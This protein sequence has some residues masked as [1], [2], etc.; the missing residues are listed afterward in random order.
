MTNSRTQWFL[1][2]PGYVVTA[3]AVLICTCIVTIFVNLSL[4]ARK[5]L[6]PMEVAVPLFQMRDMLRALALGALLIV[7]LKRSEL[8]R[9][10]LK[11]ARRRAAIVGIITFL[12]LVHDFVLRFVPQREAYDA[13]GI[14]LVNTVFHMCVFVTLL[15]SLRVHRARCNTLGLEGRVFQDRAVIIVC[16]V[17]ISVSVARGWLVPLLDNW[18]K[19]IA[20]SPAFALEDLNKVRR[21]GTIARLIQSLLELAL[22]VTIFYVYK[23][24]RRGIVRF[25][26]SKCPVCGY[27]LARGYPGCPECGWARPKGAESEGPL[28]RHTG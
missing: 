27:V 7:F 2:Q 12:I 26:A 14:P 9:P 10:A 19:G 22:L 17:F 24:F 6:L 13:L 5:Y 1:R 21:I 11:A 23:T 3:L 25:V 15:F 16:V 20:A 28:A 4:V 18:Q 8:N